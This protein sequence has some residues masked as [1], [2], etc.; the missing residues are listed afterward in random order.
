MTAAQEN[1]LKVFNSVKAKAT[2]TK[3]ARG[4]AKFN[5]TENGWNYDFYT[6][7]GQLKKVEASNHR[8]LIEVQF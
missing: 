3:M 1:T 2:E 8:E 6:V 4:M 5:Y 7:N